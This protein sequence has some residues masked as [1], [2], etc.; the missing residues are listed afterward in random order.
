MLV[1]AYLWRGGG[2]TVIPAAVLVL[3]LAGACGGRDAT[4]GAIMGPG[5][6][7]GTSSGAGATGSSPS[8]AAGDT[9]AAGAA[10]GTAGTA[11][12]TG[13]G[14]TGGGVAQGCGDLFDQ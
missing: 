14:G 3:G 7:A 5:G 6:A 1:R 13:T 4:V 12:T 2:R 8:G 9:G 10:A 11:G